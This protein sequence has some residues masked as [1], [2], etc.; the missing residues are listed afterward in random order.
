MSSDVPVIQSPTAYR[1][2]MGQSPAAGV[3]FI[4]MYMTTFARN[5]TNSDSPVNLPLSSGWAAS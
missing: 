4:L 3:F 2:E 5:E 1:L